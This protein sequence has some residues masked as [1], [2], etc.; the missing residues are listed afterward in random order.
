MLTSVAAGE[1][2]HCGT[3]VL[4]L[5]E[6]RARLCHDKLTK[7]SKFQEIL[8]FRSH[9]TAHLYLRCICSQIITCLRICM[10]EVEDARQSCIFRSRP[11]DPN[12]N[13]RHPPPWR[14]HNAQ[15]LSPCNPP[16]P[17][18]RSHYVLHH[19]GHQKPQPAPYA[20]HKPLAASY[21]SSSLS[22]LC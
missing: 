11:V 12:T 3:E 16:S 4:L 18:P 5:W 10:C 21:F 20:A 22:P 1:R 6:A 17:H 14:S 8:L 2:V 19:C 7:I 13:L 15:S 9:H